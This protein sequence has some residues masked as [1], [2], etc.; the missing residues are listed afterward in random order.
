MDP[1]P[2]VKPKGKWAGKLALIGVAIA[3]LATIVSGVES[4]RSFLV[5]TVGF[6]VLR[7]GVRAAIFIV[8][9]GY[10]G[11]FCWLLRKLILKTATSRERSFT[12]AS[13][14]FLPAVIWLNL[15]ILP[16]P[17]SESILGREVPAWIDLIFSNERAGG[18]IGPILFDN[19]I[20]A[21]SWATAQCLKA[22]LVSSRD[23]RVYK[24]EIR[25]GFEYMERVRSRQEGSEG[26]FYV[27]EPA[28]P[29]MPS[30]GVT[31]IA[32]WVVVAQVEA[33]NAGN[34]W[35][36]REV[37]GILQRVTRDLDYLL[38]RQLESGGWGPAAGTRE[39]STRTYSTVMA[40]WA[41][42]EARRSPVV[43]PHLDDRHDQAI[44]EGVTWLLGHYIDG[45][46]WMPNPNRR[47]QRGSY[48]G[49]DAQTLFVLGQIR[50]QRNRE[51]A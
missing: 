26:W 44:R 6:S 1:N 38:Q 14:L 34:V 23:P 22:T 18:G 42:I 30:W 16:Q 4:V 10:I 31:E 37:P 28:S 33:L 13:I 15:W 29:D 47:F 9:V 51:V 5:N 49:L 19:S 24:A 21:Q 20:G 39:S 3:N 12:M 2:V 40:L 32:G 25:K 43:A 41:L 36:E 45:R 8:L 48:L 7:H 17:T 27:D 46:G 35:N 50:C 11:V